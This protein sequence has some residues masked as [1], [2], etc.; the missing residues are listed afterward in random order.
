MA[1]GYLSNSRL[2]MHRHLDMPAVWVTLLG[3]KDV[4]RSQRP[5]CPHNVRGIVNV[6]FRP[7]GI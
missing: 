1:L 3:V 7:D 5:A 4:F 2:R 6:T